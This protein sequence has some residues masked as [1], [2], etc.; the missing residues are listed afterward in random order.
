[1]YLKKAHENNDEDLPYTTLNYLICE[2]MY[3]GRV[4][5]DN[6]RR[7]LVCYLDEFLGDF[8]FDQNQKFYFAKGSYNYEIPNEETFELSLAYI[9]N[10]PIFTPP[11]VF[12]LHSNAEISYFTNYAK[13][14]WM[15]ILSMQTSSGGGGAG[16]DREAIISNLADSIQTKTLPELFDE[17]NIRKSYDLPSPTQIVLLQEL[18][19]F[20]NLIKRMS[21]SIFDL[22][23][24][25]K[26]EIG[27]TADLDLLGSSF[28]NGF[29]PP[30]WARLAPQTQKNLV[31]WIA[32]FVRRDKQYRDWITIEEPM[33]IWL[34][35]LHI[36]ESYNT[37]LVQTTCRSKGWALDKSIMYTKVTTFHDAKEITKRLD[38]GTYVQGLY[39]EG[40]RWNEEEDCID[41]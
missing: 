34:S 31:N 38:Q 39:I 37:A 24:A 10:L 3:G 36:P 28:F 41:Y 32:H 14:V 21:S 7:V 2:A 22:K 5:D 16:V 26:G 19:R 8:I 11:S 9:D 13:S 25:L 35:G 6:D 23:R 15:D 40:A 20:N 27:M 33:V 18:E 4:T 30:D 12:G 17:Y 29:L 1:M